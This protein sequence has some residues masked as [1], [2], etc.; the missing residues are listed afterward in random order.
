M[1]WFASHYVTF[2]DQCHKLHLRVQ[3]F[4]LAPYLFLVNEDVKQILK[5]V[6]LQY[7]THKEEKNHFTSMMVEHTL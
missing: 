2:D 3:C 7:L 5:Y 6:D 1:L 4:A